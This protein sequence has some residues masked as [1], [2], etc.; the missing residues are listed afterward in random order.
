MLFKTILTV[1]TA[2][3]VAAAVFAQTTVLN[4]TATN[5]FGATQTWTNNYCE[6]VTVRITAQGSG[7][8]NG[9]FASGSFNSTYLGSTGA[10]MTGTFVVQPGHTLRAIAGGPGDNA[11]TASNLGLTLNGG[12]GG[13]GSGVSNQT[14]SS[15]MLLAAGGSGAHSGGNGIGGSASTSGSGNGGGNGTW[16]TGGGGLNSAGAASSSNGCPSTG[17]A[18]VSL[19]SISAGSNRCL[20]YSGAGG[21]G[22]GMGGGGGASNYRGGGGG[23]TGG[24][25]G[26]G[27]GD[28]PAQSFNTGA[29]QVNTNGAGGVSANFGWVK[30]ELLSTVPTITCKNAAVTLPQSGTLTI[31]PSILF[32]GPGPFCSALKV[33]PATLNCSNL[34]SNTV[35]LSMGGGGNP[36]VSCTATITVSDVLAPSI[37]CNIVPAYLNASGNASVATS[38]LAT[39][40][41]NCSVQISSPPANF[42]CANLGAN[43]ITVTATDNSGN[44]S[45]CIAT[46]DVVDPINP[47]V[48]CKNTTVALNASGTAT[49]TEE[50]I[51]QSSADNCGTVTLVGVNPSVVN[52]SH[53]GATTIVLYAID[54]S[55]NSANCTATVTV[56]DNTPPS[57]TCKN[58][59]V[60]LDAN[61]SAVLDPS[62]FFMSGAD[63][64]G[65]ATPQ[66]VSPATV[67]CSNI[68]TSAITLYVTDG[69]GNQSTCTAIVTVVDEIDPTVQ[70]QTISVFLNNSGTVSVNPAAVFL[71]GSDNCGTVNPLS[72]PNNMYNCSDLGPNTVFLTVTDGHGNF[73]GCSAVI[74]VQEN[75][76]PVVVCKNTTVNLDAS[77]A[78][79][80][81]TASVFQS[82]S[83]NCGT[84]N[85]VSVS[86]DAFNCNNLGANTVILTVN[87]GNGN[88]NT[89]SAT[90]TVMDAIAPTVICKNATV[91][92]NAA[93]SASLT[94]NTIFQSG[95]DNC[96]VVN[97]VSALP[98]T[99]TCSNLGANTVT[100]TVNDGHG[101][102]STCSATVTVVDA[103]A[104]TVV[105][106][107]ATVNL[108]ATGS[109]SITPNTIFQSGSDNCGIVNLV[110]VEPATFNCSTLGQNAVY[111]NVNDGH[112]NTANCYSIVTVSDITAPTAICQNVIINLDAFGSASVTAAQVNNGSFDN[113]T[114]A[115]LSLNTTN[116]SCANIGANTVVLTAKDQ[117]GNI[118]TCSAIVTVRDQI[119]PLA[120]CKNATVSLGSNGSVTVPGAT[121]NNGS[122]DNCSF[123]LSL[124]P[125]TFTCANIGANSVTLRVTD[126]DGNTATCAATVTV[127]DATAP[128]ALCKNPTIYLDATGQATLTT[129]QVNN[130]SSDN[131]GIASMTLSKTQFYCSDLNTVYPV[132]I[133][134]VKDNYN[135]TS[136]CTAQVIVKD[137]IAPTAICENTTAELGYNGK[138]TVYGQALASE[139]FDNCSV[140]SYSPIAKLYTTANIGNNNLLITVK[141]WSGNAA[142]C[143]SVVT[144]VPYSGFTGNG[145]E[146]RNVENE[147]AG[148][149]SAMAV[150]PNP[151]SGTVY[152]AFELPSDQPFT[153][154]LTDMRGRL[155]LNRKYAGQ[156]G[157]NTIQF[158]TGSTPSGIYNVQ[159][160]A[161]GINTQKRL[162]IQQL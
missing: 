34:G 4:L 156:E 144:V 25:G 135:N 105:C 84:V 69:N 120:K 72:V 11:T 152:M 121:V 63:N 68:G 123:T 80:I 129:A 141:D 29:D 148:N 6:P 111:L 31:D 24:D 14:T 134:T 126:A 56:V 2:L 37:A 60:S 79:S 100:L 70:C 112:G 78:G 122:S 117:S 20:T 41:D 92:L 38:A 145:T 160:I 65:T 88:T 85:Q 75:T 33:S 97:Q 87:D 76:P 109:A 19:T 50:S 153:V 59:T 146:D 89:C 118:G 82:G 49:I 140:W 48:T 98:N 113:C 45:T 150:Y 158:E 124:S 101:N 132:V 151:T 104:P 162:I 12:G 15:L 95:A 137:N 115:A 5:R 116:F 52:C 127:Q 149:S 93:G 77:G 54:G 17:G 155:V 21:G 18:K 58:A 128:A 143:T 99:F 74:V 139:S 28:A 130:G 43:T 40:T 1:L 136:T 83:D 23:H 147:L 13:A 103:I 66:S 35:T 36:V 125:A 7:G 8:G 86:P 157:E 161:E 102:T 91:N 55:F 46:V 73:A 96:G 119:A 22:Y 108:N 62:A 47:T 30:I 44:S 138:V 94:P 53:L 57:A 81:T 71:S 159:L 32:N 9:Y 90:V 10:T 42:T 106:K 133:L 114:I 51:Y 142:T 67:S 39:A 64:C 110:S 27:N 61:G 26:N 131:C 16:A 107:N 154:Q 3:S